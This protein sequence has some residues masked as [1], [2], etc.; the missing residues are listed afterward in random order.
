MDD[1]RVPIWW[2]FV[3]VFLVYVA[4]WND[5]RSYVPTDYCPICEQGIGGYVDNEK[6]ADNIMNWD[7]FDEYLKDHEY[8]LVED[9]DDFAHLISEVYALGYYEA[10]YSLNDTPIEFDYSGEFYKE[11]IPGL[12]D[13]VEHQLAKLRIVY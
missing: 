6:L 1:G 10:Y 13:S 3:G 12:R 7:Y 11:E 2:L 8:I 9:F 5:K 4:W